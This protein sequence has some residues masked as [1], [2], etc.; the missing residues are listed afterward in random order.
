MALS[1]W[2]G[3]SSSPASGVGFPLL[4][5]V[6]R[7]ARHAHRRPGATR[8]L[9]R[10]WAKALGVLFAVGAVSGHDPVVRD[11]PAVARA[12]GHASARSSACRSPSRASRSSSRRSSSASTCTPGTGCRPGPTC[13]PGCPIVLAGVAS[14]FFVVDRQ[15]LDEPA[16]RASTWSTARSTDVDPWAAMFNPAT[17]PADHAHDPGGVHGRR[18]RHG[19]R[20]RGGHAARPPGPLPPAG[21]PDAVH[22]S[23]RC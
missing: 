20:V 1:R 6:R 16:A 12:D 4:R 5:A 7:V 3:T 15:R 21:L 17:P 13:S 22:A 23:R 10:R 8:L 2:A 9:A 19:Q 14:A 11:G 18:L